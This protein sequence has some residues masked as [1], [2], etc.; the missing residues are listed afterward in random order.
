MDYAPHHARQLVLFIYYSIL[1]YWSFFI[2]F[3]LTFGTQLIVDMY[4]SRITCLR[5][6]PFPPLSPLPTAPSKSLIL[7]MLFSQSHPFVRFSPTGSD[8]MNDT[9]CAL[10]SAWVVWVLVMVS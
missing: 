8:E 3:L 6:P 10:V 2:I 1:S 4:R 5:I 7:L 9:V